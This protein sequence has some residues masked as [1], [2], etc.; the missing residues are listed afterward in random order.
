MSD[1][2]LFAIGTIVFF[3]GATGLVLYGLDSFQAWSASDTP[4]GEDLHLDDETVGR[5]CQWTSR[6]PRRRT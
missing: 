1:L 5:A 2:A 3:L 4:E 6:T